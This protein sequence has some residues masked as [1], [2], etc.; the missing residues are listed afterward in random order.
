MTRITLPGRF[1]QLLRACVKQLGAVPRKWREQRAEE[2]ALALIRKSELFDAAWYL[3]QNPDV[4][5][6]GLD[7]ARHYLRSGWREGRKPSSKFIGLASHGDLAGVAPLL[8]HIRRGQPAKAARPPKVPSEPADRPVLLNAAFKAEDLPA[9]WRGQ[10]PS[11][12]GEGQALFA[13]G[14]VTLGY[15]RPG[16][17]A[18][19]ELRRQVD[20]LLRLSQ[21]D[22]PLRQIDAHGTEDE[23]PA[24]EPARTAPASG[25]L[26]FSGAGAPEIADGWFVGARVLRLRF[27]N[28]APDAEGGIVTA[29]QCAP[30]GDPVLSETPISGSGPDFLDVQL[31]NALLPILLVLTSS[32]GEVRAST[33]LPFP[34]LCRGGIHD[35]EA[36]AVTNGLAG[37]DAVRGA[38]A[39]LLACWNDGAGTGALPD[40]IEVDLAGATGAERLFSPDLRAWL[41]RVPGVGIR[42]RAEE[43]ETRAAGAVWLREAVFLAAPRTSDTPRLLRVMADSVPT[44]HALFGRCQ[45]GPAPFILCHGAEATPAWLVSPPDTGFPLEASQPGGSGPFPCFIGPE[46]TAP[47]SQAGTAPATLRQAGPTP[48]P[49]AALLAPFAPLQPIGGAPA[50]EASRLTAVLRYPDDPLAA[51]ALLEALAVQDRTI[52]S[53]VIVVAELANSDAAREVLRQTFPE[54]GHVVVREENETIAAS[55]NQ[56]A[57]QARGELLL[58]LGSPVL[59]HDRRTLAHLAHLLAPREVASTACTLITS[60]P[61]P[62][63]NALRLVGTGCYTSQGLPLSAHSSRRHLQDSLAA[64]PPAS[65]PVPANSPALFLVRRDD[66]AALGGFAAGG[67]AGTLTTGFWE[68]AAGAGRLHLATTALTATLVAPS[69]T[70]TADIPSA[71]A[72]SSSAAHSA[73][74]AYRIVA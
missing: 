35:G 2:R 51:A 71:A 60:A 63:A 38:C 6:A 27:D 59:L 65:W 19:R 49:M 13:L 55:L 33:L 21:Q 73:M 61:S 50:G 41:A 64:L 18:L 22:L 12:A 34:S 36:L 4:A 14:P 70:P 30:D 53:D 26:R 68:A 20:A 43:A 31:A 23:W 16:G 58:V 57:G 67:D 10:P 8:E 66:W 69:S 37:L 11:D 32:S 3:A 54:I 1:G 40:W 74:T 52:W 42:A 24:A 9:S 7:P 45:P 46:G 28:D 48:T 29:L 17:D 5:A 72:V 44:L 47:H 15:G 62:K 56:A 25:I 39:D